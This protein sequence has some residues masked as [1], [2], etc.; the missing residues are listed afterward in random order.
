MLQLPRTDQWVEEGPFETHDD[1]RDVEK[2]PK[3]QNLCFVIVY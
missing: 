3:S 1:Q 2:K